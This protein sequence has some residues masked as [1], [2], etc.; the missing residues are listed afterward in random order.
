MRI[1]FVELQ[2]IGQVTEPEFTLLV[3]HLLIV[4]KLRP[5]IIAEARA[6]HAHV[7]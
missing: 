1:C 7:C 6:S 4:S 3:N 5:E 2:L